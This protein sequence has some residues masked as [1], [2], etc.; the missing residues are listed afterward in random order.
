[1]PIPGSKALLTAAAV[2]AVLAGLAAAPIAA[3][4][5]TEKAM[6]DETVEV[7]KTDPA[8]AAAMRKAQAKLPDFLAIAA[9]P[10]PGMKGFA[11]KVAIRDGG[12]AEYFWI[13]RFTATGRKFSGVI[14]N[15]PETV[16]TVKMGQTITFD[17]SQI[18]DWIYIDNG[19]MKGNYT[20][21]A[22]L[23]SALPEEA[24][25]FEKRFSLKCDL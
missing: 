16:H 25:E 5:L 8:M 14:N 12:D 22:I 2:A 23:A 11:V 15:K 3:Q 6:R 13:Y 21:C 20:G 19:E 24:E 17:V 7:A 9:A 1:M 10:K 18:V 4:T